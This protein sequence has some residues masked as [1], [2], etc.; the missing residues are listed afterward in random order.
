MLVSIFHSSSPADAPVATKNI[1]EPITTC[2]VVERLEMFEVK[3]V[4]VAA[5]AFGVLTQLKRIKKAMP[6][7]RV[8]TNCLFFICPHY[9]PLP[10][11]DAIGIFLRKYFRMYL[12]Q[13]AI[14]ARVVREVIIERM[15]GDSVDSWP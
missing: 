3:S 13:L 15:D 4:A 5:R 6:K 11:G 7:H 14:C 8:F 10:D 9:S 1:F 12:S 2:V